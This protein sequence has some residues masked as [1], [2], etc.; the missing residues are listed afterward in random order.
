MPDQLG[1]VPYTCADVTKAECMLDYR[2]EVEFEEGI[3]R[4]VKRLYTEAYAGQ[5]IDIC[6]E[7]QANDR[8][9]APLF[10]DLKDAWVRM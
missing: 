6:P 3:I 10:V 1:D 4:A 2:S 8:R 9:R 5:S 7:C